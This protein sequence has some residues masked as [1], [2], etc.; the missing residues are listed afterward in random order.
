MSLFAHIRN[1]ILSSAITVA[2]AL[3]VINISIDPIDQL[4]GANDIA[5]NEIESCVEF[6]VEVVLDKHNAIEETD[7]ADNTGHRSQIIILFWS[8]TRHVI[9]E[10]LPVAPSADNFAFVNSD[11]SSLTLS[12]TSPPPK[13]LV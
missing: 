7:E 11:F 1:G 9:T 4:I 12:I 6:I 10:V 5:V 2:T 8:T 3:Q 13:N